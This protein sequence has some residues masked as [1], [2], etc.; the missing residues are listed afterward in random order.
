MFS[1]CLH[2]ISILFRISA[3]TSPAGWCRT[4]K[5]RQST[6]SAAPPA[7]PAGHMFASSPSQCHASVLHWNLSYNASASWW[8]SFTCMLGL[9]NMRHKFR[10]VCS[11]PL[12]EFTVEILFWNNQTERRAPIRGQALQLAN[13]VALTRRRQKCMR[14]CFAYGK[15]TGRKS[16]AKV[17]VK[18]FG[19]QMLWSAV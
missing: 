10:F 12:I 2:S 15:I 19:G 7:P 11:P 18:V 6:C 5:A 17:E 9:V 3:C 8:G 1:L 13:A 14:F 16:F 4:G